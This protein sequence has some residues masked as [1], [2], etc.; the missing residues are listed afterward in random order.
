MAPPAVPAPAHGTNDDIPRVTHVLRPHHIAI[1]S[2][3]VLV[4]REPPS[5]TFNLHIWRVLAREIAEIHPPKPFEQLVDAIANGPSDL[6]E[7]AQKMGRGLRNVPKHLYTHDGMSQF[8]ADV[9]AFVPERDYEGAPA[10]SSPNHCVER[11]SYFGLFIR[12]CY[13]SFF[14][15]SWRGTVKLLQDYRKWVGGNDAGYNLRTTDREGG[16][17]LLPTQSD[18]LQYAQTDPYERY[19][20]A[21]KVGDTQSAIE[22]LR[23][24]FDQRFSENEESSLTQH[25]LLNLARLHYT[26]GEFV[27]A[28]NAL[29]EALK[30]ART[31]NDGL[32]VLHCTS[33]LKRITPAS[34]A[35]RSGGKPTPIKPN[36]SP[37]EVLWEVKK[38]V[39]VGEPLRA[40]FKK[41]YQ[42]LGCA[43]AQYA[44]AEESRWARHTAK[45][46]LW[47]YTGVESLAQTY[48]GMV[49]AFTQPGSDD[50]SRLNVLR[51]RARRLVR[52]GNCGGA[53]IVLLDPDTWRGLNLRQYELW[54]NEIW[55]ALQVTARRRDQEVLIKE[56]LHPQR[57]AEP[58]ILQSYSTSNVFP[59]KLTAPGSL[60]WAKAMIVRQEVASLPTDARQY[61]DAIS[62]VLDALWNSEYRGT[63]AYHR[64]AVVQ[65]ADISIEF[66]M[67]GKGRRM[68]EGCLPQI[69]N[70]DDLEI[71]AYACYVLARCI[72]AQSWSVGD[73]KKPP[74]TDKQNTALEEALPFLQ[75]A[76]RDYATIEIYRERM[77][78]IYTLSVVYHNLALGLQKAAE[79]MDER[80]HEGVGG[81][82]APTVSPSALRE[83]AKLMMKERDK[84][85]EMYLE[86]DKARKDAGGMVMDD[87]LKEVLE[88]V[89]KV[90]GVISR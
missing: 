83:R 40:V 70:G 62:P 48:E 24:F 35:A 46:T 84:M 25:A 44:D 37:L 22:N 18:E 75:V 89:V 76:E 53:L 57:P 54:A 31:A 65:L 86:V 28:G 87:E 68:I 17:L 61:A 26:L 85:A 69:L 56:F 41:L 1:L 5:P 52:Q 50:D 2:V 55:K 7:E 21:V 78:V 19:E 43:G 45:A 77:H 81:T 80:M 72:I 88:L 49:T 38:M 36:M 4:L 15:L 71:R 51:A 9:I 79:S 30:V 29:E 12:R 73:P 8:F 34:D 42:S 82:N 32:T 27:A 90:A 67:A 63:W 64:I 10:T 59:T 66:G 6:P 16:L 39:D 23:R 60:R 58:P 14:K 47:S 11:R 13:L 3:F 20:K 33:L 74:E